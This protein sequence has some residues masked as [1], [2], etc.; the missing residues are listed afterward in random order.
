MFPRFNRRYKDGKE[1]RCRNIVANRRHPSGKV[2]Q[3]QVRATPAPPQAP[4]YAITPSTS[5]GIV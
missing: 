2:M 5:T 3:R 1:L 4:G